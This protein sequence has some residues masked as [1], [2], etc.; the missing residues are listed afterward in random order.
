MMNMMKTLQTP[1]GRIMIS[2][3]MGLGLAS[4]FRQSCKGTNCRVFKAAP[5]KD[6][7]GK[8]YKKDNQCYTMNRHEVTCGSS[9]SKRTLSF[10]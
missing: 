3:I 2:I 6:I 8:I 10:A 4:L 9:D 1:A 7:E 5:L